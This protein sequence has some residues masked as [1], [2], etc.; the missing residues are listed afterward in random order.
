M[1][2]LN[3]PQ[4]LVNPNAGRRGSGGRIKTRPALPKGWPEIGGTMP[5]SYAGRNAVNGIKGRFWQ[6]FPWE[7]D[8][9]GNDS[10]SQ[11]L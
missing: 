4:I 8:F 10:F 9:A 1:L 3:L 7:L 2:S 5:K 11:E 6:V